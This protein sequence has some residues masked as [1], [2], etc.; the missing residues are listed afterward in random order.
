[1]M[2]HASFLQSMQQSGVHLRGCRLPPLPPRRDPFATLDEKTRTFMVKDIF[3]HKYLSNNPSAQALNHFDGIVLADHDG[4]FDWMKNRLDAL[5]YATKPKGISYWE[6]DTCYDVIKD[7][8]F[9]FFSPIMAT[10]ALKLFIELHTRRMSASH[11]GGDNLPFFFTERFPISKL[12][13]LSVH[14]A[15][16]TGGDDDDHP[17]FHA[18]IGAMPDLHLTFTGLKS[19]KVEITWKPKPA[20]DT[21]FLRAPPQHLISTRMNV[22]KLAVM[23]SLATKRFAD[24][25]LKSGEQMVFRGDWHLDQHT[26][27]L[28][29]APG[30][31][32]PARMPADSSPV[33]MRWPLGSRNG[34]KV[35]WE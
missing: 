11:L 33:A 14:I 13:H 30:Y 27:N 5:D 1:M 25:V 9:F 8:F 16:G 28:L 29:L 24:V 19:L 4:L 17:R 22:Q 34:P 6:Y 32:I 7:I 31:A 20:N 26:L 35:R 18:L 23:L 12:Q 10:T 15:A 21:S 2:M 3:L